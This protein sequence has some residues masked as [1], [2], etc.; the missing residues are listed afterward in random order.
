MKCI[1]MVE[2]GGVKR[3]DDERSARIVKEG[4]ATFVSKKVWKAEV[5]DSEET[6]K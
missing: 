2:D 4:K 5:R 6:A 1:R 3:L